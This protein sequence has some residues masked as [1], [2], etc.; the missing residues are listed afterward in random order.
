MHFKIDSNNMILP[1]LMKLAI[2]VYNQSTIVLLF[3]V[4]TLPWYCYRTVLLKAIK[5]GKLT[6][7]PPHT[8]LFHLLKLLKCLS[9]SHTMR[10]KVRNF[11]I[12]SCHYHSNLGQYVISLRRN[13]K[14]EMMN[15]RTSILRLKTIPAELD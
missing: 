15:K 2:I 1:W 8:I 13:T 3:Y 5:Q 10:A 14:N 6:L 12:A 7:N 11:P 4:I 9:Y